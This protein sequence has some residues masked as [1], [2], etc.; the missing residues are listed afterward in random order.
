[1]VTYYERVQSTSPGG[2]SFSTRG[3]RAS[4]VLD[5]S[6]AELGEAILDLLGT[7]KSGDDGRLVRTL[8]RAHPQYTWM[9]ASQISNIQGVGPSAKVSSEVGLEAPSLSFYE[10]YQKFRLTVQFEPRA[11]GVVSDDYI[12]TGSMTWTD[13]S[14]YTTSQITSKWAAEWNRFTTV[15]FDPKPELATAQQGQMYF[16]TSGADIRPPGTAPHGVSFGG[17]PTVY[18]PRAQVRVKWHQVPYRYVTSSN[19]YIVKYI[20]RI[21]QGQ[22]YGYP[23]GSLLYTAVSVDRYTPP[24]PERDAILGNSYFSLERYCDIEFQFDYSPRTQSSVPTPT[25]ANWIASGHNL[26]PWL[27]D[28]SFYYAISP[29]KADPNDETKWV[30]RYLSFPFDLLFSDPDVN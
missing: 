18:I 12:E 20:G 2:A 14:G 11:Y 19:S 25:N 3:G 29:G 17:T 1:M 7:V 10:Q 23:T 27:T 5:V 21:N 30:P 13:I 28:R 24:I 4:L 6:S 15:D 8:P 9:Y 22:W 16:A 26:L